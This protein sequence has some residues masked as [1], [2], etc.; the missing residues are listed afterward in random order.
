MY[1]INK[2]EN[3]LAFT[4]LTGLAGGRAQLGGEFISQSSPG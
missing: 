3:V 2:F 1:I 4:Q